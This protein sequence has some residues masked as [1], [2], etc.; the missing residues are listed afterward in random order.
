MMNVNMSRR[1]LAH[2]GLLP[3][4]K[5][6]RQQTGVRSQD[7]KLELTETAMMDSRMDAIHIMNDIR[8]LGID[9]AMDDFGTGQSSLSCLR[10]FPI[11]TLKIDRAFLLNITH[12]REFSAV[13]QAIIALAHNLNLDVVAEGLEN[14]S[15]LAQLQAMDCRYAQGQLFSMA[16]DG[17]L[18]TQFLDGGLPYFS[19]IVAA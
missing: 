14:E 7:L 5:R 10:Q 1:Q 6:I 12:K 15:Q 3:M 4:L 19:R 8:S 13:V 2:P 11:R 16:V 18:A 9:L 17:A